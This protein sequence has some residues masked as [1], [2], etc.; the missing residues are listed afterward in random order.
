M[1][2]ITILLSMLFASA[3][4]VNAQKISV[5]SPASI[6]GSLQYGETSGPAWGNTAVTTDYINLDAEIVDDGSTAAP[7]QGCN[8]LVNTTLS[9]KAAIVMRGSCEF[10]KKALNAQT[11]GAAVVFIVNNDPTTGTPGMLG[12]SD[13]AGVNIPVFMLSNADGLAIINELDMGNSVKMSIRLWSYGHDYD[14]AFENRRVLMPLSLTQPKFLLDQAPFMSGDWT[15]YYQYNPGGILTNYSTLDFDTLLFGSQVVSDTGV[16]YSRNINFTFSTPVQG[17]TGSAGDTLLFP[18]LDNDPTPQYFDM[19]TLSVGQYLFYDTA[20]VNQGVGDGNVNDNTHR[21]IMT[22]TDSVYGTT[23]LDASGN[24]MWEDRYSY[25]YDMEMGQLLQFP[26]VQ[27]VSSELLLIDKINAIVFLNDTSTDLSGKSFT[28]NIYQWVDDDADGSISQTEIINNQKAS[29]PYQFPA[30]AMVDADNL[31]EV[32]IPVFDFNGNAGVVV[33]PESVY[34]VS[35]KHTT[36]DDLGFAQDPS[37]GNTFR[38]AFNFYAQ[39]PANPYRALPNS[40]FILNDTLRPNRNYGDPAMNITLKKVDTAQGIADLNTDL[41]ISTYPNPATERSTLSVN[42]SS[43][44]DFISYVMTDITGRVV[45]MDKKENVADATFEIDVTSMP[46]GSYII[47]VQT[48]EGFN[49]K[50]FTRK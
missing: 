16:V 37:V 13:G 35:I 33:Q 46:T 22:V 15:H 50:K 36:V 40:I 9:G 11:A 47:K 42:T 43:V 23:S 41:D 26:F 21:A 25:I 31:I 24:F 5:E 3:V 2:K 49:T 12:G 19:S 38:D 4:S 8:A 1:K 34:W 14:V 45:A 39:N 20:A 48:P 18:L 10:G 17:T 28:V 27:N 7:E 29:I 6:A 30:G 32:E 44:Q